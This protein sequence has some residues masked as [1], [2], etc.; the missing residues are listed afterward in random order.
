MTLGTTLAETI[1][2]EQAYSKLSAERFAK[3]TKGQDGV[4]EVQQFEQE[5]L[6]I[7]T[8][9]AG[10]IEER[11]PSNSVQVVLKG[12]GFKVFGHLSHGIIKPYDT[13]IKGDPL[14]VLGKN[15]LY[16]FGARALRAWANREGLQL[17]WR[18]R[19]DNAESWWVVQAGAP[20]RVT[21]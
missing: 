21:R 19:N 11:V 18:Q 12:E 6:A 5:I 7:Q 9:L 4:T 2:E 3:H 17:E 8:T 20:I 13:N 15:P 10:L 1:K 14:D 16:G